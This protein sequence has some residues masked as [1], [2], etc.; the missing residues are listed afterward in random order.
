MNSMLNALVIF[1][2]VLGSGMALPQARQLARTHRADGVSPVWVGVSLALNA[3]W[4]TYA[5]AEHVWALLP[6]SI[7]LLRPVRVHGDRVR[8]PPSAGRAC[9]VSVW[10]CSGLGMVPLPFLIVGGW[11]VAGVVVGLC[12]G[13]QLLPAVVAVLRT[14]QLGGVSPTTWLIAWVESAIWLV[15]GWG[16]DDVAL[17]AAGLLGVAMASVI[18]VRLAVTGHQP[19]GLFTRR[20]GRRAVEEGATVTIVTFAT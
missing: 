16:R 15:Y 20:R 14:R 5:L 10:A 11:E 12:Y 8:R 13:L 4:I 17:V 2:T 3:W 6:V 18:L 7:D 19:M 1:A 9:A